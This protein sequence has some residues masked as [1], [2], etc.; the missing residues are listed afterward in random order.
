[1][2][3]TLLLTYL[4]CTSILNS[5]INALTQAAAH[6][7]SQGVVLTDLY[8]FDVPHHGSQHNVGPTI[9]DAVRGKFAHISAP[10]DSAKHPAKKVVNALI[11]R[12]GRVYTTQGKTICYRSEGLPA[13]TGWSDAQELPF[14]PQVEK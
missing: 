7:L 2:E 9:L 1:M 13:R 5:G 4:L 6:A 11:R 3:D 12:G 14:N 10:P 8:L